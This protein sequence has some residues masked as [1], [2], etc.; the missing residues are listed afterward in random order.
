MTEWINHVSAGVR[1]CPL[2]YA[3]SRVRRL[4]QLYFS[5]RL[6]LSPPSIFASARVRISLLWYGRLSN[7]ANARHRTLAD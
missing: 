4:R 2:K 6:G 3:R 1:Q 5:G 7:S